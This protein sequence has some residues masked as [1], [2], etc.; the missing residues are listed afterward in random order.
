M[1]PFVEQFVD[2]FTNE[3]AS[4]EPFVAALPF[5]VGRA[6][7]TSALLV[8]LNEHVHV[9]DLRLRLHLWAP[10][11]LVTAGDACLGAGLILGG[12]APLPVVMAVGAA[13]DLLAHSPSAWG[14]ERKLV[15][16]LPG[17]LLA[18]AAL[19]LAI[20]SA[21]GARAWP[22]GSEQLGLAIQSGPVVVLLLALVMVLAFASLLQRAVGRLSAPRLISL[23]AQAAA[24]GAIGLLAAASLAALLRHAF[25]D[26]A[27][28]D[29]FSLDAAAA[30]A[31][32]TGTAA[33]AAASTDAGLGLAGLARAVNASRRLQAANPRAEYGPGQALGDNPSL[34]EGLAEDATSPY[35][36]ATSPYLDVTSPFQ[37]ALP[38]QLAATAAAALVLQ[39]LSLRTALNRTPT[40]TRTRTRTRTLTLTLTTGPN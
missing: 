8:K 13:M 31:A 15:R 24:L 27:E 23:A 17:C 19:V 32:G 39:A 34:A 3:R 5:V 12:V 22:A 14:P 10:S 21:P 28:A 37:S 36:D 2:V 35:L 7:F 6:L 20:W 18:A 40:R 26:E 33:A 4:V 29:A 16:T 11:V 30:G 1:Q 25:S 9:N 38:L